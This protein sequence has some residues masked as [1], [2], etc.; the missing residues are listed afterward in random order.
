MDGKTTKKVVTIRNGFNK[1][2]VKNICNQS[3][4]TGSD[5]QTQSTGCRPLVF[6]ARHLILASLSS[7]QGMPICSECQR[8]VFKS[9]EGIHI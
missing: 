4:T 9:P 2:N 1:Q 8:A 3:S 5:Q 7:P 6:D